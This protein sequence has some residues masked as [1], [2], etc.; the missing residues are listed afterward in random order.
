MR[1]SKLLV[2]VFVCLY[3]VNLTVAQ[4]SGDALVVASAGENIAKPA[5]LSVNELNQQLAAAKHTL[6]AQSFSSPQ[7][8]IVHVRSRATRAVA[9][10]AGFATVRI[11]DAHV[12]IRFVVCGSCDD[13]NPVTTG[14]VMTIT[15]TMRKAAKVR[16]VRQL[17]S[18]EDEI[19]V[20][21][22]VEFSETH[23]WSAAA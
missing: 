12:E 9:G 3:A 13:G 19:I 4:T 2:Q 15:D 1:F 18:F 14:A 20:A 11:E 16:D 21:E 23:S 5:P 6:Q 7:A 10:H 8:V 17:S 22:T